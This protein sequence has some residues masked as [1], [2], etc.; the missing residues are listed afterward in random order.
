MGS[1]RATPTWPDYVPV[2]FIPVTG[3]RDQN[4]RI[5][6]LPWSDVNLGLVGWEVI[7]DRTSRAVPVLVY[8]VPTIESKGFEIRCHVATDIPN[9]ETDPLL[10]TVSIPTEY[11]GTDE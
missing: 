9:P 8:V 10:G 2:S 1:R 4:H 5:T 3:F 7:P 6:Y 11:L